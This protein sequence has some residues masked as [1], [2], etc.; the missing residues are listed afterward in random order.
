M[1]TF[2]WY[3]YVW[4]APFG[5]LQSK[6]NNQHKIQRGHLQW[7]EQHCTN[8]NKHS[9]KYGRRLG[10]SI[11]KGGNE[12]KIFHLH[13]SSATTSYYREWLYT[14]MWRFLCFFVT[15]GQKLSRGFHC[16]IP[17]YKWWFEM[18]CCCLLFDFIFLAFLLLHNSLTFSSALLA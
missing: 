15:I 14:N 3:L 18:K 5:P 6:W 13:L 16:T 1:Q 8:K 17:D 11:V 7:Q 12:M 4:N 9:L 10:T 2:S